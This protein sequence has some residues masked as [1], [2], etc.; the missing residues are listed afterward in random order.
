M[1]DIS[2]HVPRAVFVQVA[3]QLALPAPELGTLRALYRRRSTLFEHQAWASAH[4]GLHW[5]H[6]TDVTA[7]V[8]SL[9]AN[10]A[11]TLDRH[12]LLRAAR[13]ALLARGCLIPAERDIQDWVRRG[14]AHVEAADRRQLDA[15][16]SADVRENWLPR[17]MRV[18]SP[19][20]MTVLEWLRRPPRRRSTKTLKEELAKLHALDALSP[21]TELAGI[22]PERLRAYARRMRRRRPI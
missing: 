6:V 9:V 12:R 2:E 1:L 4:A 15:E 7:V 13:E 14:V 20:A 18:V 17:L 3:H 10:S 5:P 22:P 8:E 21:P 19:E 16:V 11:S